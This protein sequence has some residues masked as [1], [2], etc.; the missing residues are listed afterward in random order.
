MDRILSVSRSFFERYRNILAFC[1]LCVSIFSFAFIAFKN[2]DNLK[3]PYFNGIYD[4]IVINIETIDLDGIPIKL[5]LGDDKKFNFISRIHTK[6]PLT[7]KNYYSNTI[8]YKKYKELSIIYPAD[9]AFDLQNYIVTSNVFIGKKHFYFNHKQVKTFE[10]RQI[11][12]NGQ[13]YNQ[14]ILPQEVKKF[15]DA[16]YMNYKGNYNAFAVVF[17]SF[18]YSAFTLYLIP[19]ILFIIGICSLKFERLKIPTTIILPAIAL[20][21]IFLR[22]NLFTEYP[23]WWD[24]CYTATITGDISNPFSDIFFDPGNPP[25][26]ALISRLWQS[27]V[28]N[29]IEW[30]RTLPLIFSVGS[31]FTLYLLIKTRINTKTALLASFML[32]ISIFHIN[33][34][35]DYRAFSLS[36]LLTP[37]VVYFMFK[38]LEKMN[39]LNTFLFILFSGMIFNNHL[40]GT[41]LLIVNFI[42]EFWYISTKYQE[43]LKG[44]AIF[45]CAHVLIG[46]TFLPYLFKTFLS[47]AILNPKFNVWLQDMC[48]DTFLR[49]LRAMFGNWQIA[50]GILLI[51]CVFVIGSYRWKDKLFLQ[52]DIK[53][54]EFVFYLIYA[55]FGFLVVNITI[56]S[57][58]AIIME[59]Y[60]MLI[61]PLCIALIATLFMLKWKYKFI[62]IILS[63]GLLYTISHMDYNNLW[64]F[65]NVYGSLTQVSNADAINYKKNN[66]LVYEQIEPPKYR[67]LFDLEPNVIV[68]TD[69]N[70]GSEDFTKFTKKVRKYAKENPTQFAIFNAWYSEVTS[71]DQDIFEDGNFEHIVEFIKTPYDANDGILRVV[72]LPQK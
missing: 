60:F 8:D 36:C 2:F 66:V 49:A 56:S 70:G 57:I 10:K 13:K 17:L 22:F 40:Y 52:M 35:Q 54:R 65:K 62:N 31:I 27:F 6:N 19:W 34:A 64:K 26:F 46:L 61:Y 51:S 12:I 47:K 33:Y 4:D 21:A 32:T 44:F 9:F 67:E 23:M 71:Q 72:L 53:Q 41:I 38:M 63:F 18:F 48:I 37:L 42:Y 69:F 11:D 68:E 25:F 15:Q 59:Y 29:T 28:P 45:V 5:Y 50:L 16:K 20:L 7:I 1:M 43:K 39:I 24:E 58:R 30:L 55:V 3:V 14:I